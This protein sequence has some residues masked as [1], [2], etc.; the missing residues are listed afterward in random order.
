MKPY[1]RRGFLRA[2]LSAAAVSAPA[3]LYGCLSAGAVFRP[4]AFK[5]QFK[6]SRYRPSAQIS[7]RTRADNW[8]SDLFGAYQHGMWI[9]D[10]LVDQFPNGLAFKFV[11]DKHH[12]M[13][14]QSLFLKPEAT[15]NYVYDSRQVRFLTVVDEIRVDTSDASRR[16]FPPNL[17][18]NK[19]Y[20]VIVI[21]SGMGGGILANQLADLQLDVL[22]LEA[23]GYLVP[24]HAQNS[25]WRHRVGRR[26]GDIPNLSRGIS[27]RNY[28]NTRD[29]RY[30][31]AQ[32]FNLGGRSIFWGALIPRMQAWELEAWP[33][34]IKHYLELGGYESAERLLRKS[35]VSSADQDRLKVLLSQSFPEYES[36]DAPMAIEHASPDLG[37]APA[38][39]FS[40]AALLLG[41]KVAHE[42]KKR[43]SLTINLNHLVTSIETSAGRVTAVTAQDLSEDEVRSFR[44]KVVVLSCGTL[45]SEK[46]TSISR[47]TDPSNMV[48]KGITCHPIVYTNFYLPSTSPAYSG[49]SGGKLL[50]RH[51]QASSASHP[52]NVVLEVGPYFNE[53]HFVGRGRPESRGTQGDSVLCAIGFHF[54]SSLVDG[55]VLQQK[56]AFYE[57]PLVTMMDSTAADRH[58]AEID[59]L[60]SG[61]IQLLGGKPLKGN[62]LA[63]RRARLGSVAHEVGTLRMAVQKT[64]VTA[65]G[66][67][68]SDLRFLNYENVYACDLSVFPSSPAANPSLTLAALALRLAEHL[69]QKCL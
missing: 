13:A 22:V 44:G 50:L 7:I 30:A 60:K 10:L 65:R 36:E 39:V 69:K 61:I 63:L 56:G 33:S 53:E 58:F 62:T 59:D 43:G 32:A 24:T 47:L 34:E 15:R 2:T 35:R 1:S 31:G 37:R 26:D 19:E 51:R 27:L 28:S 49:H 66:V 23:G 4:G 6:T 20:D 52:Y 68:D 64:G 55:N 18:E 8:Q 21:G 38:G 14:G 12:W 11:L 46:L 3:V 17:N 48:G 40:T 42:E 29:S 16:F 41:F 57:T 45:E 5:V 25:P 9:F 54:N 67:L